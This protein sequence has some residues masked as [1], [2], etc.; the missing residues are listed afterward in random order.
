MSSLGHGG[1]ADVLELAVASLLGV[2]AFSGALYLCHK[3]AISCLCIWPFGFLVKG[4]K[5]K[6]QPYAEKSVRFSGSVLVFLTALFVKRD[7]IFGCVPLC[8][9]LGSL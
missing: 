2:A 9:P 4:K 3:T 6:I 1:P 5:G 8:F 7:L